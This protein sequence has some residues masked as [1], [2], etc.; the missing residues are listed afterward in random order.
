[1]SSLAR[2]G[3]EILHPMMH[4]GSPHHNSP[5]GS[6]PGGAFNFGPPEA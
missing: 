6:N 2:K 4:P 1:M 5:R 3:A